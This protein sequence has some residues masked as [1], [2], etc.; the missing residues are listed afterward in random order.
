MRPRLPLVFGL[1]ALAAMPSSG[2]PGEVVRVEHRDLDAMPTRGPANAPVTIELFFAPVQ[3]SRRTEY[4]TIEALQAKHPSKIRLVYRIIKATGTSRLHYAAL[5]AHAEGKFDAFMDAINKKAGALTDAQLIELAKSIDM[6][7]QQLAIVLSNPPPAYDRVLETNLRRLR[8]KVRGGGTPSVLINGH[9]P[10]A[11]L[12][13]PNDLEREYLTAKDESEELLDRGA[14]PRRLPDA[15]EA[16]SAPNPLEIVVATGNTDD[17][18]DDVPTEPPLATP[19]L[20][21]RGMPSLGPAEAP[22]TI[23]VL[24]SPASMNCGAAMRAAR[25]AQDVFTDSVRVVWA[26]YFDVSREDA[27]DLGLLSDAALCAEKVGTSSDDFESPSSQGWRWVEA[28]LSESNLRHRRVPADQ[29]LEKVSDRLHVD[30]QAFSTCRARQAG[31]AIAWIEAARHAGVRTSPS[32]VVG[33]RIY[34]SITEANAL[35]QLVEA[36]LQPGD[37]LGCLHLD[38]YAP[39]WRRR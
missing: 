35:Q 9:V 37:C 16:Q 18:V 8:K 30:K 6:D 36:E 39:T 19:A 23:A 4:K 14:D 11:S 20:D 2:A 3:S 32:T 17:T 22:V 7:L 24:C 5:E 25:A 26:P 28:M 13:S 34:P 27:A 31:T 12:G 33:G 1:L 21:L 29:L 38:D 10:R 15:F